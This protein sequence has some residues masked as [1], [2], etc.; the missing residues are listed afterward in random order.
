MMGKR[1]CDHIWKKIDWCINAKEWFL[2]CYSRKSCNGTYYVCLKCNKR[3][4]ATP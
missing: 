1:K 3:V 4:G 2:I